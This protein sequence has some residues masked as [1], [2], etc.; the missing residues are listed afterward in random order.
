MTP[1]EIRHRFW[2]HRLSVDQSRRVAELRALFEAAAARVQLLTLPAREQS[3]AITKLEEASFWAI[4]SV[5]R[6][7]P[8]ADTTTTGRE[9][10]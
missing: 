6:E 4:S 9:T 3:L 8:L 10:P 5:A 7:A 1:D 2:P